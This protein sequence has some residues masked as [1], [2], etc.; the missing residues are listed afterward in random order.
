MN[1]VQLNTIQGRKNFHSAQ[2]FFL[3]IVKNLWPAAAPGASAVSSL[4]CGY[5]QREDLNG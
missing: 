1:L 2:D 4:G 3:K 5:Q